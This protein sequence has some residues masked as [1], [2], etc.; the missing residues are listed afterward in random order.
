MTSPKGPTINAH[1]LAIFAALFTF[2]LRFH[3]V[4]GLPSAT[5]QLL[6]E[7]VPLTFIDGITSAMVAGIPLGRKHLYPSDPGAASRH[8]DLFNQ[9]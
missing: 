9:C 6:T 7:M 5:V 2:F 3:S 8:L 1:N 4:S